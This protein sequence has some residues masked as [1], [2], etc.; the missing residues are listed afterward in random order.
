MKF[1]EMQQSIL[2]N[3][4]FWKNEAGDTVEDWDR[5]CRR[6]CHA[7]AQAEAPEDREEWAEK[8]YGIM[9]SGL[10]LPNSPTLMNAGKTDEHGQ[11][12]ACYVLDVPDS[13]D[14]IYTAL[15]DQALIFKT[16]G[17]VGYNFSKLRP[18]GARVGSTNG[19]AS[20]PVSFMRLFDLSTDV[21]HQGGM[22][23]GA[24]MGIL[25]ATHPDIW[26]FVHAKDDGKTLTNFNLSVGAS[27]EWMRRAVEQGTPEA[28]LF[29]EIAE[30]AWRCGDPG[31]LFFDTINRH[32]PT[33]H[34]GRIEATNPCGESP[35][36][37]N[38]AC[39]LG[40]INLSLF[41]RDG[42]VD[43]RSLLRVAGVAARFLD[44]VI[45]VNRYPLPA[46][47]EATRRTR[48]IGLGV[49]GWAHMLFRLGIPYDSD[50]AVRTALC[51]MTHVRW[52]AMETSLALAKS[53]GAY[54]A[55]QG[56]ASD[57]PVRNATLTCIAPTG[58]ISLIA[59]CSSGIEPVFALE[60]TRVID[61]GTERERREAVRDPVYAE[62]HGSVPSNVFVD[63][64][65]VAPEWHLRH[66]VAFGEYTDLAV[67]KTINLPHDATVEDVRRIYELAWSGG[68]KGITVYR[69]GSREGQV[70]VRSDAEATQPHAPKERPSVLWGSTTRMPT[71]FGNLFL[72]LNRLDDEP[73]ELFLTLGKA[74]GDTQAH[75]E[76]LGRLVSLALRLGGRVSDVVEQLRGIRGTQPVWSDDGGAILSLPDAV[77]QGLAEMTPIM[78]GS[79]VVMTDMC[80]GCGM[81]LRHEEGCV[82][83]PGCGYSRC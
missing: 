27:D 12:A 51:V 21:V 14:G 81:A 2:R 43:F 56:D 55:W 13:M 54:P 47:E 44:D 66:Q 33:P 52:T 64:H 49:M 63:A 69:D 36:Y 76:A 74:G 22:R 72:T 82:K 60:H 70:L 28:S 11:L 26:D 57:L 34:L 10:F 42:D 75:A 15:R 46:V 8:F 6:V 77:A 39:N 35:L 3:R 5:L 41:V 48:K 38:E 58:T 61:G 4:Y 18:K 53:R 40:S 78:A 30:S 80:P 50:E 37:P 7:V 65:S 23:R 17:G 31:M 67:S 16:G 9:H 62:M 24:N 29:H 71:A 59:G 79:P 83:C 68:C 32:N 73:F 45:D 1:N 19:V 20:G 25:D